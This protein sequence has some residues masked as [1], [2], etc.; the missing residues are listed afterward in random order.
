MKGAIASP[1]VLATR[2]GAEAYAAGGNAIDAAL[3]AAAV[4]TVVYPHQCAVGGD[5]FALVDDGRGGS[6]SIN[7][8]GAAPRR[9]DAE[10]LRAQG[11]EMPGAGPHSITV[12]GVVA[13]WGRIAA[14]G[15]RLP[16][17]DLLAPAIRAAEEGVPVARSLA[18]GIR[19]R[20]DVLLQDPGMRALLFPGGEPLAEGALLRQPALADTLRQLAAE[21]A[22]C[23][24]RG[25]LAQRLTDGLRRLGAPFDPE[26]FATH[27]TV[28]EAPLEL[29]W[30]GYTL[31]TSPPNSQGF[32]LLEAVA[33]LEAAGIELDALGPDAAALLH[34]NL[35]AAEDRDRF[36]GDPQR[37][38]LPLEAL[39]APPVLR[40]RLDDRLA[41]QRRH[42]PG[43]GVPAHGDTVAV[44]ALDAEGGAV[45]LIQSC[46]QTFGAGLLD[47]DTGVIFHNRARGFSLDENAANALLPGTRPMH[48]LM[49][50]LVR[51]G[52]AVCAVLGTMG[53][54]AQP[55]IL[56][57]LLPGTLQ[58]ER[59]LEEVLAAP[60]W[61]VGGKDIGFD[62]TTVAIEADAPA[63]LD[64]QLQIDG[65][66]VARIAARSESVGHAQL[67]RR[68]AD[69]GLQ[70]AADP[71]SDG[72]AV[73]QAE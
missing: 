11:A 56:A 37:V 66:A 7:G 18:A 25:A 57:Q 29:A 38:R 63:A 28:V 30:K 50:L 39:L 31:Q 21:G 65:V 41:R 3:A 44:C 15:A 12:P 43:A 5:L 24:Y 52:G 49:P 19:S 45:S 23:F 67:I 71:R 55:Q 48:T 34:A 59:P 68:S 20:A 32:A 36:L 40:E 62:T 54:R 64:E 4:L 1:H 60:R 46:Y 69:G 6:R 8:S 33:A 27:D 61:V 42:R 72:A 51:R 16:W 22:Q 58:W 10:A 53:G 35:M 70:A 9:V 2:A 17:A 47:P 14:L 26:D 13:A 73:I